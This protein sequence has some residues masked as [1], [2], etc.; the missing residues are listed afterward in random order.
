MISLESSRSYQV[1]FKIQYA[2][3]PHKQR[4]HLSKVVAAMFFTHPYIVAHS[5]A[6]DDLRS[7]VSA[8]IGCC[9][10]GHW[11]ASGMKTSSNRDNLWVPSCKTAKS[12]CP[13]MKK[14]GWIP[15]CAIEWVLE[16]RILFK[17]MQQFSLQCKWPFNCVSG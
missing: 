6:T 1:Y 13:C 15:T 16:N 5:S 9:L 2:I 7:L 14:G 17:M 10:K 4:L 3:I 11:H 12:P 8:G